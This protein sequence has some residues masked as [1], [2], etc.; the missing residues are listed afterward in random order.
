MKLR[1]AADV[2]AY[3]RAV[4]ADVSEARRWQ[5]VRTATRHLLAQY[6]V[7]NAS[8][9]LIEK[10]PHQATSRFADCYPALRRIRY[11]K[12]AVQK[13]WC[14]DLAAHIV[15]EVAHAVCAHERQMR[16]ERGTGNHGPMWRGTMAA[17][18]RPTGTAG[19][20]T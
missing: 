14:G 13:W 3:L 17:M 16:G 10:L 11:D 20:F 9:W 1:T 15:H 18:G 5:A 4:P 12:E 7:P 8:S 19:R 6:G 2:E